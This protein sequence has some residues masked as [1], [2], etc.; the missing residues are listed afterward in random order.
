MA[1]VR[2]AVK[3]LHD[4]SQGRLLRHVARP[5]QASHGRRNLS[6]WRFGRQRDT[7]LCEHRDQLWLREAH[8][9][10]CNMLASLIPD[11][12]IVVHDGF[13][14]TPSLC[15]KSEKGCEARAVNADDIK[16]KHT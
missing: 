2:E 4:P 6:L 9:P 7:K 16:L 13:V 15:E 5:Y 11:T 14:G 12:V 10:H 8:E 3:Q 1:A